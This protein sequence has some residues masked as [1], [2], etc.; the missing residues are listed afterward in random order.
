MTS[1]LYLTKRR[2]G[3]YYIGFATRPEIVDKAVDKP[4]TIVGRDEG[5]ACYESDG[6]KTPNPF[7]RKGF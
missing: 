5:Y 6:T 4:D 2:N 3:Y 7:T 1:K